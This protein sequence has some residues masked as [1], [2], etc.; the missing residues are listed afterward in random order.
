MKTEVHRALSGCLLGS[1]HYVHFPE[2]DQGACPRSPKQDGL[3]GRTLAS[4][5]KLL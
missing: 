2:K 3:Q 5:L 1:L 4:C